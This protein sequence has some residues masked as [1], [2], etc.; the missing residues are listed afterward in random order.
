MSDLTGRSLEGY[1]AG[2]CIHFREALLNLISPGPAVQG[3]GR[4]G[5][6]DSGVMLVGLVGWTGTGVSESVAKAPWV[7]I[8]CEQRHGI[9]T[10][11]LVHPRLD[12]GLCNRFGQ[13]APPR[14]P[15]R[16]FRCDFELKV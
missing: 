7:R 9:S 4:C 8:G 5:V 16:L 2:V 6:G 15:G 13:L 14:A 1:S 10:I 3:P 12:R 11:L